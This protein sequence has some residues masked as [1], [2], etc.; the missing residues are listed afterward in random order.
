[1]GGAPG[2]GSQG[3][4]TDPSVTLD[5]ALAGHNAL[6][7]APVHTLVLGNTALI[8]LSGPEGSA[9]TGGTA[10]VPGGGTTPPAGQAP[11]AGAGTEPGPDVAG[12]PDAGMSPGMTGAAMEPIPGAMLAGTLDSAALSDRVVAALPWVRE[13]RI[14][15]EPRVADRLAEISAEVRAGRPVTDFLDELSDLAATMTR[16]P[17]APATPG[18]APGAG[19][20]PPEGPAGTPGGPAG[21]PAGPAGSPGATTP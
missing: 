1:M 9:G 14:A 21:P 6:G 20:A 11:G 18:A 3:A 5:A 4:T 12:A 16:V 7:G 19:G 2:A 13:I 8:A 15:T 17:V 10:P